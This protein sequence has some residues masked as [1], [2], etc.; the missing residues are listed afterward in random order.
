M[1][2]SSCTDITGWTGRSSCYVCTFSCLCAAGISNV[3]I[4]GRCCVDLI[5]LWRNYTWKA[6]ILNSNKISLYFDFKDKILVIPFPLFLC[7]LRENCF[8]FILSE[9][10]RI[11]YSILIIWTRISS[12]VFSSCSLMQE[13]WTEHATQSVPFLQSTVNFRTWNCEVRRIIRC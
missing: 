6:C 3:P 7:S 11:P 2:R 10:W 5:G 1:G 9:L 4:A 8:I 13:W 12:L